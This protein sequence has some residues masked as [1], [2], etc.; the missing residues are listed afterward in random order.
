MK[1]TYISPL[2]KVVAVR[3]L[4]VI[5][6]SIGNGKTSFGDAKTGSSGDYA[7]SRDNNSWDIWGDGDYDED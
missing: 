6:A 5:A 3:Q 1:K 2:V 4:N 7:D